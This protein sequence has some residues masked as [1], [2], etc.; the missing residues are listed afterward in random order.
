MAETNSVSLL[1]SG[2]ELDA[3]NGPRRSGG[4]RPGFPGRYLLNDECTKILND[5][6]LAVKAHGIGSAVPHVPGGILHH[7]I[8]IINNLKAALV[9]FWRKLAEC[10]AYDIHGKPIFQGMVFFMRRDGVMSVFPVSCALDG[11][12]GRIFR[13]LDET[14]GFIAVPEDDVDINSQD[15]IDDLE[16]LNGSII[17]MGHSF[18]R[19]FI[20]LVD[21]ILMVLTNFPCNFPEDQSAVFPFV[22]TNELRSNHLGLKVAELEHVFDPAEWSVRDQRPS[23]NASNT[24]QYKYDAYRSFE[25]KRCL[26]RP[27]ELLV[28]RLKS[29][30]NQ[31]NFLSIGIADVAP[32]IDELKNAH[33]SLVKME[34]RDGTL[35]PEVGEHGDITI[36]ERTELARVFS[37]LDYEFSRVDRGRVGW[38]DG[39]VL[40]CRDDIKELYGRLIQ[41]LVHAIE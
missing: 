13:Y 12:A 37:G 20:D 22:W 39:S 11:E 16:F 34:L 14:L 32:F 9:R 25:M 19:V 29:L 33:L 35:D 4:N 36:P 2:A 18:I 40:D 10:E 3:F 7:Y 23:S 28:I 8:P 24:D 1:F 5:L 15:F 27:F 26:V 21:H 17:D 30:K 31:R 6:I 41:L 38:S